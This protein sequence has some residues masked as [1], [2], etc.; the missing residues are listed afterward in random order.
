MSVSSLFSYLSLRPPRMQAIL[1]LARRVPVLQRMCHE[2][3]L[4]RELGSGMNPKIDEVEISS[5]SLLVRVL[6]Q[7]VRSRE[8]VEKVPTRMAAP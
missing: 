4:G 1:K 5:P 3:E 7:K 8:Q 2:T 6:S